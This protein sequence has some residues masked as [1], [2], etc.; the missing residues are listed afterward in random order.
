MKKLY[1]SRIKM[2]GYFPLQHFNWASKKWKNGKIRQTAN[3]DDRANISAKKS[4]E[5]YPHIEKKVIMSTKIYSKMK[6]TAKHEKNVCRIENL[7]FH[8]V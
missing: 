3:N 2:H 5:N 6:S 1:G 4:I 8:D 7:C